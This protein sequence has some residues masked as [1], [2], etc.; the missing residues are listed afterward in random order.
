MVIKK[1][2]LSI[3]ASASLVASS[4]AGITSFNPD[5]AEAALQETKKFK[6]SNFSDVIAL[7]MSSKKMQ[8]LVIV[9]NGKVDASAQLEKLGVKV[10][11][12]HKNFLYLA[13]VPTG[14]IMDVMGLKSIRTVGKNAE[15]K[16]DK[17]QDKE[18]KVE[19]QNELAEGAIV[20]PEQHET[21]SSTG[22]LDFHNKFDGSGVRI[23][24]IDSGPDP[25]HE[26]FTEKMDQATRKY[27]ESKIVAVRDYT[28][29]DRDGRYGIY[30][31]VKGTYLAE[32][33]VLYDEGHAEGDSITVGETTYTTTGLDA[34]D[35]KLYFSMTKF[36]N[37][38]QDLNAD[39]AV[40][41]NFATLL[42][43]DKVYID[44]D[45][46]HD[47]TDETG[48]ANGETGTFDVNVSDDLLGAN[49]RI[50][51]LDTKG[52]F[53]SIFTD[54]NG[55]GSHVSGI[56]AADGPL[57]SNKYGAVAGEGV[58]PGAELVGLRVFKE[59]GGASTFSIQSAMV[60]AALP[61]AAGGFD[62][63]VANLSLGSSP[64]LNEGMGSYGELMELLSEMTDIIFVT[65]A[66]NSG[67][68]IDTVGSP[69]DVG[70]IISVGAHITSEMWATEYN[71]Y[72]YGKNEDG[73]PKEGEGLWYFSSVGPNEIG[74]QKPDIVGPGSAYAA[75]PVQAGPYV[76][77]QGTSMSS[78]YVAGA[79]ALL[80][81]AALKDRIPFNYEI[82]R[83]ALIQ[84][85]DHLDGYNRAQEGAGLINVPAAYEYLRKHFIN[86][87]K[88]VDVTV[89]HGEK[90][91][92]G[93]GL[94]V[95]NKDIP[96]TVEVLIEN[97]TDES[98]DLMVS[99]S[100]DW[101]TPSDHE[102]KLAPGEHKLITVDYDSSKLK[103]GTNAGTLLIDDKS[104]AYV[105]ARSAQTIIVGKKF[106]KENRFRS[107]ITDEVQASKSKG[108]TFEVKPG[109]SELRFSLNAL[110]ENN[111]YKGRVR[112]I[113]FDPD[114]VEVSEFKGY[115][116][117]GG[118]DVE[119]DVFKSPKPG[120]WEVHVYGTFGPEKGKEIN[121]YQL[122][123]VVQ[124][125]VAEPGEIKLGKVEPNKAITKS[126]S[127]SNY[128][129]TKKDVKLASAEF[130]SPKTVNSRVEVPGNNQFYKQELNIKNNVSLSVK[131]SN[132]S[133]ASDDVDLYILDEKGNQ[134]G[135]SAGGTSDEMVTLNG[136]AD[137]KYTI[138][139]EGYAT[140]DPSTKLDLSVTELSVL[141][142]GEKGKGKIEVSDKTTSLGVGKTLTSDV[143]ITTPEESNNY[144][145]AVYLLDAKTNEVLSLLPIKADGDIITEVAGEDRI[146][147]ALAV[148]KKLYP[149][150]FPKGN[151]K[152]VILTTGYNFP[153]AL[154]AGPLASE[155][156]API[157]PVGKDGKLTK[158]VL[159]EIERLGAENVYLLG[160]EAVISPKVYTQLNSLSINSSN[161]ERLVTEGMATRYGTN[162]AV[163]AK[164]KE[165]GF[166]GDGVFLATGEN[167]AD[168]LSAAA[169]A[170]EYNMPIVLTDGKTLSEEAKSLLEN[171]DVYVLGGTAAISEKVA[172]EADSVALSVNRLAGV[173]RYG[174]L[175]EILK[176]FSNGSPEL[177][178]ASGKNFPDALSAAPLVTSNNGLLLLVDP[179]ELPKEVDSF[180]TKYV[181]TNNISTI[182]V[183]GGQ[184]AVDQKV[185]DSLHKKVTK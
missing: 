77:M 164:L 35:D 21:H 110:S 53:A 36:E 8:E 78:P 167:F 152:T 141:S 33:D 128:L 123:A 4:F 127:F 134:V 156:E 106:T 51:D 162:L 155:L 119:D 148:S 175:A 138:A 92:G 76:V 104:T 136:L 69:G 9:G 133:Y 86:D 125:V 165:K 107:R 178:V 46:D 20:T 181:Y 25:G 89:Y 32:G 44:T 68:G 173:N 83:E 71:A 149:D 79:V 130:S 166:S 48:Y 154:S 147:T 61:E 182:T 72:P 160:G 117:Y 43:D 109:V 174:T 38:G 11:I 1:K 143:K 183:L 13:D 105:E 87:I 30:S 74:N 100:D 139:I 50:S 93:P 56:A 52:K 146:G 142:P 121:K 47:F 126:V 70:P 90:I 45:N 60:D 169:V 27:G 58:A 170:G 95:R 145:G 37:E 150:G 168:A 80:K 42:V 40:K 41:D 59:E 14:K 131:T 7:S 171:E 157:L 31:P 2:V 39:G 34:S 29:A 98:K 12:N 66:G 116:G 64:D 97:N 153:D 91:S 176:K 120:V 75:H 65:S 54:F 94:Y 23:G 5:K 102:V 158:E 26:S 177:F 101:F 179:N 15:V 122:E 18:L 180:L 28:I 151:S 129:S 24:I 63:D 140:Q 96:D 88:E 49:F 132:P 144:I 19:G 3:V 10:K 114:G 112:M 135:M 163:A 103:E 16:V 57:R 185:R 85:A 82:A 6:A 99:A 124:D 113:V 108:Y 161:I 17:V 22:V 118:M 111:D 137:G 115:A 62:V 81:S 73:T 159:N 172:K 84:T 67:P 184:A 55:H